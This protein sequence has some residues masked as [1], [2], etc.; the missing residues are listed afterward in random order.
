MDLVVPTL[1]RLWSQWGWPIFQLL[2]G[3]GL[4][5]FVHEMGHFLLAK[6]AGIKVERF[7]LGFGPRLFGFKK[8]DTD[9][10]VK[11]LPLG[12]Y[13]KMLGQEDL[14][15]Q[16]EAPADPRA[17]NN[18]SVGAR[19][20]VV[21]AGVV[22]NVIFAGVLFVIVC[23]I[24]IRFG[25]PVVGDTLPGWPASQ[26]EIEWLE[27]PSTQP[28]GT[29][30][31]RPATEKGLRAGDRI[32]RID[33]EGLLLKILGSDV[34]RFR[35]LPIIAA[36]SD[37]DDKYTLT[38]EREVGGE[39]RIGRTT[40][41]LKPTLSPSGSGE[42]IPGFGIAQA[43]DTL[44]GE[45]RGYSKDGPFRPKDRV[46]A[47]DGREIRHFW[48]ITRVAKTFTG[49]PVTVTV[50]RN[51]GR[52][53]SVR[54]SVADVRPELRTNARRVVFL[55]DGTVL[56]GERVGHE[57]VNRDDKV[58][59][60]I[61]FQPLDGPA[62]ELLVT[63]EALADEMLDVLGL[64]PRVRV[65][66]VEGDRPADKAGLKAGDVI[67]GYGDRGAPTWREIMALS[68]K[69]AGK[70]THIVVWRG[71][72]TLE[73]KWIVPKRKGENGL[74]GMLV[75]V[76]MEHLAVAGV[77]AD[78]PAAGAGLRA[79]DV[80]EEVGGRP[81]GSWA[82]L[83]A[84]LREQDGPE[85]TV[86]YRRGVQR[87][88][89]RVRLDGG[90]FDADDY[91]WRL[92]P[93]PPGFS[94]LMGPEVRLGPVKALGWGFRETFGFL[95]QTYSTLRS[96]IRGNI[97]HKEM[98]GPVGIASMGIQVGRESIVHF[99]YFM[100]IISISLAVVNFLPIPV[101]D[102]GLAVFLIIEKIRG[103]PL[104][105]RVMNVVQV[106]GLAMILFVFVAVTWSDITRWLS[107]W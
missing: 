39:T 59:E 88:T 29:P 7:A 84:A 9:Y 53:G 104:S 99:I 100:A 68:K 78:S 79:G 14:K 57:Y 65:L 13:V 32:V 19:L 34:A 21:S 61:T 77:R 48:D 60:L 42:R 73:P 70:G 58:V 90:N 74:V 102:G 28:A 97:S 72:E 22:M 2:V 82:E 20:L 30:A 93:G 80:V 31:T 36:L 35:K 64:V 50:L 86:A 63:Q 10:C 89:A 56:R 33:G 5:I 66:G 12:G 6:A 52:R 44:M 105:V 43:R 49:Q 94:Q 40:L 27:A 96:L 16:D 92:F 67:V 47:V 37:K 41:N 4:V 69:F 26:A 106:I 45:L 38:I 55:K 23:L 51:K 18:K 107:S 1:M 76:D 101:V 98:L 71:G 25:A 15:P 87:R 46:V 81:V 54:V 3:L 95:A 8:G 11:L 91:V 83:L 103:R 75:G 62:V 24:G 17:F 85:V